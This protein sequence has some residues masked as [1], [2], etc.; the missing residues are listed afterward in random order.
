[1]KIG[2]QIHPQNSRMVALRAGWQAGDELGV[3]EIGRDPR[4]IERTAWIDHA[5]P[6]VVRSLVDAGADHIILGLRAPYDLREVERL[7]AAR[8]ALSPAKLR[9]QTR[10]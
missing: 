9:T 8:S 7:V 3:G 5:E 6:D 1:V 10:D 2:V 4:K